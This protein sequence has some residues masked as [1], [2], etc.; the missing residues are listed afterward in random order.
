VISLG[1]ELRRVQFNFCFLRWLVVGRNGVRYEAGWGRIGI[2]VNQSHY[3]P[4]MPREFQEVKVP[5][6]RDSQHMK[7]VRLSA[8]RTG[9]F[10]PAG[11]TPG[12]HFC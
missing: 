11:N 6:L 10:Y 1:Y 5:R 3:R 12:T 4:E 7:V 2:K 8:L 9:R